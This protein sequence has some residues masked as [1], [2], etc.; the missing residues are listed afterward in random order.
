MPLGALVLNETYFRWE[1]VGASRSTSPRRRCRCSAGSPRTTSWRRFRP[2]TPSFTWTVDG[3]QA[4]GTRRQRETEEPAGVSPRAG[5]D[6]KRLPRLALRPRL[7]SSG[8]TPQDPQGPVGMQPPTGRV[9]TGWQRNTPEPTGLG[10]RRI[11]PNRLSA[12]LRPTQPYSTA[13]P[14]RVVVQAVAGSSPVAHLLE[15]RRWSRQG[16]NG[17]RRLTLSASRFGP[18]RGSFSPARRTRTR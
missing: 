18:A 15:E 13:I 9:T 4:G 11:R 3:G 12:D 16:S 1:E 10:E 17:G 7:T 6:P 5:K 8:A 2:A 14:H